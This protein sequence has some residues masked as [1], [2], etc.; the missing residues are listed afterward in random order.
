MGYIIMSIF[1]VIFIV[2]VMVILLLKLYL[3]VRQM[4]AIRHNINQVPPTFSQKITLAQHQKAGNYN[5]AKL[6]TA[7]IE[8]IYSSILILLWTI[9]GGI[10]LLNYSTNTLQHNAV[11]MGVVI[12]LLFSLINSVLHLPFNLYK[13][14]NIEQK[15]GFNNTTLKLFVQDLIKG[16]ILSGIIGIPLLYL[17]LW[18][19]NRMGSEWWLWV[20]GVLVIFN[21]SLMYIYP[22]FIAPLFNK[23]TALEDVVLKNRINALLTKCGFIARGVFVM[24]GSKRSSHGN[25][26]F[27]GLGKAKRIVFFDT[28]LKQL[29]HKEIEAVLAHE[30]GHFKK[31]HILKKIIVSFIINLIVLYFM[32]ILIEQPLFYNSLGVQAVSN[33]NGLILFMLVFGLLAVP[34]QPLSSY[35]S[36]KH[37]FEADNFAAINTN[38]EL[39]ISGLIKMYRDNASTLTPDPLYVKFYYSHPPASVRIANLSRSI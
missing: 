18:L 36:R 19:I 1:E 2:L 20:W 13:T 10:T 38:K 22:V 27:T 31:K 25:A 4:S 28:L 11:T 14:F 35:F 32:S 3:N 16:L 8:E 5:L 29:N 7:N 30:L 9:G 21:L 23:F 12:I 26:Y 6:K 24:D 15:F 17:V 37:E 39:L 34:L 33:Y